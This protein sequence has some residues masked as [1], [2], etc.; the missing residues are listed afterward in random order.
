[1]AKKVFTSHASSEGVTDINAVVN[2]MI[3]CLNRFG[4]SFQDYC[5]YDFVNN[6]PMKMAI[7]ALFNPTKR[8]D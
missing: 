8:L 4:I 1:M 2:D 6:M 7:G 3:Y 5:V